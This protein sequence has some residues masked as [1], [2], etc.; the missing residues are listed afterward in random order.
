MKRILVDEIP[1]AGTLF[2]APRDEGFHLVQVLR[3]K[4]GE[5]LEILDGRGGLARGNIHSISKRA[6]EVAVTSVLS[7]KRESPLWLS[8]TAALPVQRGTFDAM[9]PGLVQLG[10]NRIDL[11]YTEFGGRLKKDRD[12]YLKRLEDISRQSLKQ[13]GR[14]CLPEI[15]CK[16][17]WDDACSA[18]SEDAATGFFFHPNG[19]SQRQ[20]TRTE[21]DRVWLAFGPEGGFSERETAVAREAGL[22]PLTM[23][24]RILKMETAVIGAVYWAQTQWGD[25]FG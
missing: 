16:P 8:V 14:L 1:A 10:V 24:P 18:V 13:C 7:A 5:P 17:S 9:L 21:R 2:Q 25:G 23:G 6:C 3:A 19:L 12:K 4:A 11:V 20:A 15:D 22:T